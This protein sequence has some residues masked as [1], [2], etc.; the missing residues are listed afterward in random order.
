MSPAGDTFEIADYSWVGKQARRHGGWDRSSG[1]VCRWLR[2][3]LC[4]WRSWAPSAAMRLSGGLRLG[5]L[6]DGPEAC[7]HGSTEV[8]LE[9]RRQEPDRPGRRGIDRRVGLGSAGGSRLRDG[10]CR[11]VRGPDR[12]MAVK[13]RTGS[14]SVTVVLPRSPCPVLAEDPCGSAFGHGTRWGWAPSVRPRGPASGGPGNDRPRR[15]ESYLLPAHRGE[16]GTRAPAWASTTQ[17]TRPLASGDLEGMS[18]VP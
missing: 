3:V 9:Q 12:L 16:P 1:Y 15:P 13:V 8:R 6:L 18:T 10:L 14:Y 4:L 5:V 7:R 2:R 11:S 17:R